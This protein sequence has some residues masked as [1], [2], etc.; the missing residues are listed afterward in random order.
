MRP[1]SCSSSGAASVRSLGEELARRQ[2]FHPE[3]RATTTPVLFS[4]SIDD[5]IESWHSRNGFSRERMSASRA[6]E[7]DAQVRDIVMPYAQAGLLRYDV[8][9]ELAWGVPSIV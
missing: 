9:V 1:V 2:L 6:L 5:Y 8:Q 4:Q 7:F 3:G